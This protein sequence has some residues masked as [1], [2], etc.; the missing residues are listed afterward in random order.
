MCHMSTHYIPYMVATCVNNVGCGMY[1]LPFL[2]VAS[3][4]HK[5]A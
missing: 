3:Y 4:G 2:A 5:Q 1:N